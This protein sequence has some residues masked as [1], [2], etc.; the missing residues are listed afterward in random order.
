MFTNPF[1]KYKHCYATLI[2]LSFRF[3]LVGMLDMNLDF[4]DG[5]GSNCNDLHLAVA[6]GVLHSRI[7]QP[8]MS[9]L[10]Q[11]GLG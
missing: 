1:I 9:S 2:K 4:R 6:F 8:I 7:P 11:E 10:Y 5:E 3:Y